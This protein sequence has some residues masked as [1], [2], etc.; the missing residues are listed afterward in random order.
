MET[1]YQLDKMTETIAKRAIKKGY[2]LKNQAAPE[3]LFVR[4]STVPNELITPE[5]AV[6][7]RS[8]T[9][10][11]TIDLARCTQNGTVVFNSP[12]V[13]ANAVKELVLSNL[14]LSVRP[15]F[16]AIQTV[17]DLQEELTSGQIEAEDVLKVAE[18]RR[19]E[20][21]GEELAGKTIGIL[22]LGEIGERVAK[23]C[24]QLGMEVLGY[25]RTKKAAHDYEQVSDLHVLLAESDFVVVLLPLSQETH[26]LLNRRTIQQMKKNAVLM[27][28]GRGEIVEETAVLEALAKN[29]LKQ[30]ITDFPSAGL[31][32]QPKVLCYPHIGGSTTNALEKGDHVVFD[33]MHTYLRAGTIQESINFPHAEL[34]FLA[35]YRLALFYHDKPGAFAP[36]LRIISEAGVDIDNLASE[37]KAGVAYTL[38]DLDETNETLVQDLQQQI[39]QETAIIRA[40]LIKNSRT[41]E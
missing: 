1:I 40:R 35:P 26:G 21:I 28:F 2:S 37:R 6:I 17:A 30:Y 8:G 23:A 33:R 38:I 10:T 14:F 20:V 12:G 29:Q 27:N 22:G 31:I 25:A 4:S 5:L 7:A 18:E 3:A 19:K 13:N 24:H 41:S 9:G 16:K 34:P 15:L 11:N 32:G 36:L 39:Q